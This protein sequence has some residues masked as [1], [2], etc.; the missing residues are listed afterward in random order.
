MHFAD[1]LSDVLTLTKLRT[2]EDN[3]LI[4][5]HIPTFFTVILISSQTATI[6]R[7][8]YVFYLIISAIHWKSR[9]LGEYDNTSWTF[10]SI[11][12][13]LGS[14][15]WSIGLVIAPMLCLLLYKLDV[16]YRWSIKVDIMPLIFYLIYSCYLLG[17]SISSATFA[18]T[19]ACIAMLSWAYGITAT[20]MLLV[21]LVV[22]TYV[23]AQMMAIPILV[24]IILGWCQG[25]LA[26][27]LPAMGWLNIPILPTIIQIFDW[28]FNRKPQ[29]I[30]GR[31]LRKITP[32]ICFCSILLAILCN[33]EWPQMLSSGFYILSLLTTYIEMLFIDPM[34][35]GIFVFI[36]MSMC[37]LGMNPLVK[38]PEEKRKEFYVSMFAFSAG[39]TV[40][41]LFKAGT[42]WNPHGPLTF[43]S[44]ILAWIFLIKDPVRTYEVNGIILFKIKMIFFA[45][46]ITL[47]SCTQV[48]NWNIWQFWKI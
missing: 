20:K 13:I 6:Y 7:I 12:A 33:L 10:L 43:I 16:E 15:G 24:I 11:F 5:K 1:I 47:R 8:F 14:R 29:P 27:P 9:F 26:I 21:N 35:Y 45:T 3:T 46:F 19:C 30:Q 17:L 28:M 23:T 34:S 40:F 18:L 4:L 42:G 2:I 37:Y 41:E 32:I 39:N 22:L 25:A 48:W 36:F 38:D 31:K 44:S